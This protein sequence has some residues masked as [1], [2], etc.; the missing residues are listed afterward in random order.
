MARV[1]LTQMTTE[2][3]ARRRDPMVLGYAQSLA[4]NRGVPVREAHA[5]A[6]R[7]TVKSLP[8]GPDTPGQ[9]LRTAWVDGEEVG[10][11]WMSM[12][13]Y[14][15]AGSAWIDDIAVDEKHRSHGYGRAVIEAAESELVRL[16]VDRLGLNVFGDN[17][18]ARRLY[19]RMG[20]EV[21]Q[22]QRGRSLAGISRSIE[23]P[24]T[25]APIENADFQRRMESL[26]AVMMADYGLS[27]QDAHKRAWLPLPHGVATEDTYVRAVLAGD[28]QIG[29]VCYALS[30]GDR[31]GMGW[32][33][34]LDIDPSFRSR[35]H[36]T[37]TLAAV[38]ADLV[39]RGVRRVGLGVPGGNA[40][41][42][43]LA[44]RLGFA[45]MSQQMAKKLPAR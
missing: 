27:A 9:L 8:D 35:G 17:H 45:L 21:T 20:F 22:Q 25:L 18:V 5:Q 12:P 1:T 13:G 43:R 34:R 14:A 31:P 42:L 4:D 3:F 24:V 6:E 16:G 36:G 38:E 15:V 2:E 33:Y 11:I 41:A 37:A 28:A 10:W 32:I 23:S 39:T 7:E 26:V 29:W 40:G 44:E 30:H 19:E